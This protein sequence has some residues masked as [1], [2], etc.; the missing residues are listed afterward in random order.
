MN[1]LKNHRQVTLVVLVSAVIG[2]AVAFGGL[3]YSKSKPSKNAELKQPAV[4]AA[5]SGSTTPEN[6]SQPAADGKPTKAKT[7]AAESAGVSAGSTASLP[8]SP[9][10]LL[11][12]SSVPSEDQTSESYDSQL[13]SV[14]EMNKS[15]PAQRRADS[16]RLFKKYRETLEMLN[17]K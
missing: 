11:H 1:N 12:Q 3:K 17:R 7:G 4:S 9:E 14:A 8:A 13:S 5:V 2:W 6:A 10:N 16:K 15:D